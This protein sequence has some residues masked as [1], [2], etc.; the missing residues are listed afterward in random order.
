[1]KNLKIIT[2]SML[3]ISSA[4]HA[5]TPLPPKTLAKTQLQIEMDLRG[6]KENRPSDTLLSLVNI[7]SKRCTADINRLGDVVVVKKPSG[8]L[9]ISISLLSKIS[10]NNWE[11]IYNAC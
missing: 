3:I 11:T 8:E 6:F 5:M 10:R 4:T 7:H 9:V 2:L 1:M